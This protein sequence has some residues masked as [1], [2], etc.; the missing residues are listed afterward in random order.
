MNATH[1]TPA[2]PA[3]ALRA[4]L[5]S[6]DVTIPMLPDFAH[7]VI[8]MVSNEDVSVGQL[9]AVVSKDQ[10]LASRLLGLANS[11]YFAAMTEVST[12]QEAIMRMGTAAVRNLVVTV[13]FYSRTQ[14]RAVYG[15]R[16]KPLLEHGLGTAYMARLVAD[17]VDCDQE[18]AFM[19]GL[20]HDIG[21]LVIL[22]AAFDVRKQLN[23]P[24]PADDLEE[25]LRERHA[26][27]GATVLR[28]WRLPSM[29]DE[30]IVF[31]HDWTQAQHDPRKAAITYLANR[32]SHRYGFGCEPEAADLLEDPVLGVLGLD[33]DWLAAT[34]SRAPGLFE[35]A[36]K[37]LG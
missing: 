37:I 6:P 29:L 36:R 9:A 13:C 11:A 17:A 7:R 21:K 3:A 18:E 2:S 35:V 32:L 22:K 10:V 20:L 31:H 23:A 30:P 12:V 19:Y 28:R 1:T 34:D 5:D 14:D 8:D 25:I 16:G 33:A 24:V 15:E 27:I 26:A 4:R